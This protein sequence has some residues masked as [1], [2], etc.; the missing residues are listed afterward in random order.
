MCFIRFEMI[1]LLEFFVCLFCIL[2]H[3]L[4]W[5]HK[6]QHMDQRNYHYDKLNDWNIRYGLNI[7]NDDNN[8]MDFHCDQVDMSI[9]DDHL[10][11]HDNLRLHRMDFSSILDLYYETD[12][13]YLI[14]HFYWNLICKYI[15]NNCG[16]LMWSVLCAK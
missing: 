13:W 3:N 15:K 11:L 4:H 5:H 6:Y 7:Q 10:M 14:Y 9:Q 2:L 16:H 12:V 8:L 1:D